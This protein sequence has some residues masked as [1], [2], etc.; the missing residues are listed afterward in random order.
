MSESVNPGSGRLPCRTRLVQ[1]HSSQRISA[2]TRSDCPSTRSLLCAGAFVLG[3]QFSEAVLRCVE[4][5]RLGRSPY[6]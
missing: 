3:A 4:R 6:G 1:R 5:K 2:V